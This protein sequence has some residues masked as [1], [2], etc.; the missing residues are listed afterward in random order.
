MITKGYYLDMM[1]VEVYSA[2]T[3]IADT[4]PCFITDMDDVGVYIECREADLPFVE[5]ILAPYV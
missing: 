4:V 1:N 5:K 2:L 3:Y